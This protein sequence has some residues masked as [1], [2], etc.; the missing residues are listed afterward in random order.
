MKPMQWLLI[1]AIHLFAATLANAKTIKVAI[2]DTGEPNIRVKPCAEGHKDF[3]YKGIKDTHGHATNI[4]NL[5]DQYAGD[6]DYCQVYIKYYDPKT[7]N[8]EASLKAWRHAIDLKVDVVIYAGG[9]IQYSGR[10]EGLVKE[11]LRNGIFIFA[12]AGN[13]ATNLEHNCNYY[14][15]C[16]DWKIVKVGCVDSKG[17]L[18][19]RSN[20]AKNLENFM[21][22]NGYERSAGGY[23]MTGTSQATAVVTGRFIKFFHKNRNKK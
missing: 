8:L 18:C 16:L 3:T 6:A 11:A 17:A 19:T 9:G 21:Y 7:D 14:P 12:A 23:T 13:E 22:E 1:I 4:S 5:I 15:A 20:Y 2:L 10:E